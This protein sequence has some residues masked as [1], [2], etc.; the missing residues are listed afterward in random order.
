MSQQFTFDDIHSA[1]GAGSLDQQQADRFIDYL[2]RKSLASNGEADEEQ[3]RLI[4]S[5]NDIFV[6][7]GIALF[8]GALAWITPTRLAG[9]ANTSSMWIGPTFAVAV[10]SWVLAEIFTRRRRMAL[11]SLVLL[12]TFVAA[13][14]IF[15]TSSYNFF[16]HNQ[17]VDLTAIDGL[18]PIVASLAGIIAAVLH[19]FRFKVPVTIAAGVA[20]VT[21]LVLSLFAQQWPAMLKDYPYFTVLPL[22]LVVLAIAVKIDATD[23]LRLTRRTD[24]AFWLHM[25]AA[26]LIV[27]SVVFPL[28]FT[29]GLSTSGAFAVIALFTAMSVLALVIDRRALLV[30]SLTYFGYAAYE[31][32]KLA[33]LKEQGTAFA[34]LIVG[35]TVLLLSVGWPMLRRLIVGNLGGPL[36]AIVPPVKR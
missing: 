11:P 35:A 23:R 7:I 29:G 2:S 1:V 6:T 34:T 12:F 19:W 28:I 30:S 4:T 26:P 18:V 14:A 9:E 21:S 5:F 33:G 24:I 3:F 25:L 22:G 36:Q 20:A 15:A 13:T 32:V 27:H 8:L 16:Q 17:P 31:M 10:A